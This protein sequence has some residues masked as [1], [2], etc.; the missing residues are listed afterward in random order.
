MEDNN[1][2]PIT[3]QEFA[4]KIK[5]KYPQYKD[6]DDVTLTKKMI[7]KY[8]E[9]ASQVSLKKKESSQPTS[10]ENLWGSKSQP[11]DTYTSLVIDQQ[12]PQQGSVTSSGEQPK[13]ILKGLPSVESLKKK[14]IQ[15]KKETAKIIK[16]VI[17]EV[18]KAISIEKGKED[19]SEATQKARKESKSLVDKK[20]IDQKIFEV[21]NLQNEYAK[22]LKE[23]D[24]AKKI[25]S[26]EKSEID[27][28]LSIGNNTPEFQQK[29][30]LHNA[31]VQENLDKF[32]LLKNKSDIINYN[33]KV[34]EAA[35]GNLLRDKAEKGNWFGAIYNKMLEGASSITSGAVSRLTDLVA[36]VVPSQYLISPKELK[37]LKDK[38]LNQDQIDD[39]IK[40]STK[41]DVIPTIR[42]ANVELLGDKGTTEEYI[43]KKEGS[44]LIEGGILGLAGSVPA[45]MGGVY[46]R[47]TNFF[48]SG[49]DA[50]EQEME[51]NPDFQNIS[52]NEKLAVIVPIGIA[53]AVLEE[54]GLQGVM[55]NNSIVNKLVHKTLLKVG[56]DA[57]ASTFKRAMNSEIK[58]GIASGLFKVGSGFASEAVTG[59][60]Q[61]AAEIGI[62]D[63][64]NVV[65][66]K[67]M[68]Q[69]PETLSDAVS[70]I[71]DAAIMEGIGGTVMSTL[72]AISTA[73]QNNELGKKSTDF[74]FEIL[75]NINENSEEFKKLFTT[76]L[77][78]K[79]IEGKITKDE[80]ESQLKSFDKMTA[81]FNRM[82]KDMSIE[83]K[84]KSFDLL[85][86]KDKLTDEINGKDESLSTK[87]KERIAE[88]NTEL[89][90]I[91]LG[92]KPLE[93]EQK[94]QEITPVQTTEVKST[95]SEMSPEDLAKQYKERI[96]S[97][98]ESD[99]EQYW[100]VDIP[101]DEVILDAAKNRRLVDKQGG[102]G[103]VTEDGNMIGMF[104][105]DKDSKGTAQA[106]QEERIKLGGIKL[107]NFDGYL[108][109]LY[110]KNGFRVVSRVPF[111]EQYAPEG[112]NKEKHGT[113]DVV[114]MVYDPTQSLEIEEKTFEDYD[115]AMAYRDQY[116]DKVRSN[117]NFVNLLNNFDNASGVSKKSAI[118]NE[119]VDKHIDDIINNL[120]AN[121]KLK[122][123]PCK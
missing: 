47:A 101:S 8:P 33:K 42:K 39:Y 34:I 63:I 109:K 80:A 112:W 122:K 29:I 56:A 25:L 104:K 40:K 10:Q 15:P 17:P 88:I 79:I 44:G 98:K 4:Q 100:S 12:I 87:Q 69:T 92:V 48:L 115:E 110:Q 96:V 26:D 103:I 77:K 99:P 58:S 51:S 120:E 116:V 94:P 5:S 66:D 22:S 60:S 65:K 121:N 53:N 14:P 43:K 46:G 7:E 119:I 118:A 123:V 102:M 32:N 91:S 85:V 18:N 23:I 62:K 89:S 1:T 13:P 41:K 111:N 105:Y 71:S 20:Q 90:N 97:I 16:D 36:E 95:I 93:Q 50:V 106:V 35:S 75:D 64:Y 28:Q 84:K 37:G 68:F 114:A 49:S 73:I 21:N 30:A 45:M 52:E 2:N 27:Y 81:T 113:P 76:D 55:K 78:N 72:P 83:D 59:G 57:S 24:I 67:N 86:E 54:F 3:P 38:G 107:D 70:Q 117:E 108:T 9:Y 19:F 6:I 61:Q 11:T 31:K 74:E 82:P